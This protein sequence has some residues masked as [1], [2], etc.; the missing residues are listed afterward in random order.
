MQDAELLAETSKL[1]LEIAAVV[2]RRGRGAGRPLRVVPEERDRA[3][4][5]RACTRSARHAALRGAELGEE[6]IDLTAQA[7]RHAC[8]DRRRPTATAPALA[9]VAAVASPTR[10]TSPAVSL[11][12]RAAVSTLRAISCVA[13]PCSVTA[14]AI[15]PVISPIERMVRS[16]API[17]SIERMVACCMPAICAVMSS[18]ARAV[19]PASAFTS[20]GDHREAAPGLAG[21]GGLD[22]GVERQ[23]IGLLGDVGDQPHHVADAAGGFV[24]LGDG[25]V[26]LLGLAHRLGGDGVRLRDLPVDLR[27]RGG[28][29]VGR[30]RDVADIGGGVRG[31]G[32]GARRCAAPHCRR[33]PT[34]CVDAASIS[35]EMRPSSASVA[36]TSAPKRVISADIRSWRCARACASSTTILLSSSLRRMASWNTA[37]ERAKRADLVA[38]VAVGHGHLRAAGGDLLGD[39]G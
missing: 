25:G 23:Q 3:R 30:G 16:I 38:A 26:G 1:G 9:R 22:G 19:W 15:A 13:A 20:L 6:L 29:L 37:I 32:G 18:V 33:R 34:S 14:A 24:E 10:S 39:A 8:R 28:E 5:R 12:R 31:G 11:V 35:S 2:R 21:A 17:A 4:H 27:H 7:A 36:S